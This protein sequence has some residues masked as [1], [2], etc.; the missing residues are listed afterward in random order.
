MI[1]GRQKGDLFSQRV[2]SNAVCLS[3]KLQPMVYAPSHTQS[4]YRPVGRGGSRGSLEPPFWP[5]KDFIY[6]AI[7]VPYQSTSLAA[8]QNYR[9]PSRSGCSYMGLFLEDQHR[10]RSRKLFTPLR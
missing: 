6:T 3:N 7:G 8:I 9:C 4:G 1:F 2:V 10:M 5:P